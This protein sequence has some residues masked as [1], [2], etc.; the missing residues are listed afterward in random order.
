MRVGIVLPWI[1]GAFPNHLS[2]TCYTMMGGI[3]TAELLLFFE[4]RPLSSVPSACQVAKNVVVQDLGRGGVAALHA[5][6]ILA[7]P[8]PNRLRATVSSVQQK[9]E[10]LFQLAPASLSEF[11][12]TWGWVF[13]EYLSEY[14]HWTYTDSDV[15]FG[16]LDD[17][18]GGDGSGRYDIETWSFNGDAGRLFLR[19]QWALH[20]NVNRINLIWQHCRH[21]TEDLLENIDYKLK[22]YLD[23]KSKKTRGRCL[24]AL[25]FFG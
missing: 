21:L 12:P 17:W 18:L 13:A 25:H 16:R 20:R 4:N 22:I 15:I 1:G 24:A 19:G 2:L 10:R 6:R 7:A 14:S 8:G 11:K 23:L 9:F 5:R 3:K